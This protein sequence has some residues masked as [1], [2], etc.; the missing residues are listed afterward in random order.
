MPIGIEI[1][2]T[3]HN[4]NA[5]IV[6][7]FIDAAIGITVAASGKTSGGLI[8]DNYIRA[9][10]L[11]IDENSDLMLIVNNR[12]VSSAGNGYADT[13]DIEIVN[14]VGNIL[15]TANGTCYELPPLA[16]ALA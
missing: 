14:C 5:R 13:C 16:G 15:T 8:A 4:V 9:T 3:S 2:G 11:A 10:G 7:N 12:W 1:A 6:G